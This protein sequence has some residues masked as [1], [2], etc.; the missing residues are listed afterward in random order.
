MVVPNSTETITITPEMAEYMPHQRGATFPA[1]DVGSMRKALRDTFNLRG[2]E[3]SE[4]LVAA[5]QYMR[6]R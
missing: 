1:L 3:G 4:Q 2:N 5:A 6:D